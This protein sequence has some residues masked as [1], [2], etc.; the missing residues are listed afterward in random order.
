[1]E[2]VRYEIDP[3]N[4]LVVTSERVVGLPRQ[5]V[6][7]DGAF[8]TD[9]S[10][11]LIY[12]IKSPLS[13]NGA[14][15][16]QLKLKGRWSLTKEHNLLFTL[17]KFRRSARTDSLEIAGDI[18]DVRDNSILFSV[19]TR[20]SDNKQITYVIALSGRWQADA[21]NR[22]VFKME[23]EKGAHDILALEAG[24]EINRDNEI[25]YRYE[26]AALITKTKNSHS[27]IFKGRWR[28]SG[29]SFLSYALEGNSGSVFNFRGSLGACG[30]DY[31]K[32]EVGIRL[33]SQPHP[34]KRVI[35]LYGAWNIAKGTGLF[36]EVE[37]A[38]GSA[39]PITIAAQA[40]LT[41][42]DTILFKLKDPLNRKDLGLQID[43]SHALLEGDGAAFFR[44]LKTKEESA[45]FVG[46][47][48]RW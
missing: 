31:I 44:M 7:L 18:I 11:N 24:W 42:K 5:R 27:L 3:F 2:K 10:N 16:H 25:V 20:Q 39:Y 43:L 13:K 21:N 33:S 36:F 45:V 9:K 34:L 38:D 8:K 32:Y 1:M 17:D 15:P 35:T 6:V 14:L 12:H 46:A 47:G 4:R 22:L 41:P 26:K 19:T 37:T 29:R 30:S 40:K 23:R 48:F 28:I